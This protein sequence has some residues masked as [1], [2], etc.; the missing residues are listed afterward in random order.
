MARILVVE[1]DRF[2]RKTLVKE[3]SDR[4]Y[5]V[6]GASDGE[7]ALRET[8]IQR[9]DLVLLDLLLPDANGLDLLG[10]L[11]GGGGGLSPLILILSGLGSPGD[12]IRGL[13]AGADD[14]L[15]KPFVLEELLA[16][17]Q[18]LLRRGAPRP[19]RPGR[20]APNPRTPSGRATWSWTR[21]GRGSGSPPAGSPSPRSSSA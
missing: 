7:S 9:F 3:L 21:R 18:A 10:R 17:V 12:R 4:G 14:Y 13:R 8:G 15:S 19:G 5:E 11:R 16:H 1:D 2:L 20:G 6:Q